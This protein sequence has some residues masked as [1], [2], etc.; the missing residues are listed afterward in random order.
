VRAQSATPPTKSRKNA[1]PQKKSVKTVAEPETKRV[2]MKSS[3][4]RHQLLQGAAAY[5]AEFGLTA[6]T[7]AVAKACGV[8]QRLLYRYFPT[9]EALLEEVYRTAIVGPFKAVWFAELLDR[10]RSVENRLMHFYRDYMSVV[11]TRRWLRLFMYSSLADV[12]M[13]PNYTSSMILQL[14]EVIVAEAAAEQKVSPPADKA[15]QHEIGWILHGAI[16]HYAIRRHLY[17]FTQHVGEEAVL[18]LHIRAFLAGFRMAVS[19]YAEQRR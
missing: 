14:L 6:Q 13:A 2:R 3:D 17:G 11:F 19:T 18:A 5:F 7:R 8:S 12:G 10:S 16:S 4:R 9:K 1:A 15:A